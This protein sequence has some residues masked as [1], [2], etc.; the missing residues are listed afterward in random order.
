MV[1]LT[2]DGRDVEV[3]EGLNLIEA[4]RSVGIEIPYFCYHPGLRVVGQ[5]RICLVEIEGIPKLQAA[6][7]TPVREGM[8]VFTDN[9]RVRKL[10]SQVME[11]LLINHPL[12]CP[13]CDQAGECDLQDFCE[14]HS[15]PKSR[16]TEAKRVNPKLERRKIGP[17]VFQ[18]MNRCIHCSRC[19]RF[20][21]EI[22]GTGELTFAERGYKM[23][24]DTHDGRPLENP[25]SA[26]TAD[27]CPVGALTVYD[28][29]FHERSWNL[30][31]T[32]SI[33][34]HCGNGCAIRLEHRS[35]S[36]KR[37]LPAANP[38]INH[39]WLCDFG[40]FS[41]DWMNGGDIFEPM[42]G[43][44]PVPWTD[45]LKEIAGK[46]SSDNRTVAVIT[47]FQ[48]CEEMALLKTIADTVMIR[49]APGEERKIKNEQGHWMVSHNA[50]PNTQGAAALGISL[51]DAYPADA[52]VLFLSENLFPAPLT[53]EE[54]R[55]IPSDAFVI[56]ETRHRGPLAKRADIVLPGHLFHE[57]EGT[58]LNDHRILQHV[59]PSIQPAAGTRGLLSYGSE[60]L[61]GMGKECPG[62]AAEAIFQTI[63]AFQG[64][65]YADLPSRLEKIRG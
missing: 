44:E 31:S 1:K 22:A 50:G 29:R 61:A 24:I 14:A 48:S 38:L 55:S 16:Y 41:Y 40:R 65:T 42:Q 34:P 10:R 15:F 56:A 7:A 23:V 62:P 30:T 64:L 39:H 21:E 35:G 45:A 36:V 6:C 19:I 54:V 20:C 57:K 18:N 13:I 60:I 63:E 3:R 59:R 53:E 11:F 52:R 43:G 47:P 4:A 33:C 58:Y 12:D 26:C 32:P 2:M 9:D 5:C 37:F 25:W 49:R 46:L 17:H 8:V 51:F 27:I 28:F